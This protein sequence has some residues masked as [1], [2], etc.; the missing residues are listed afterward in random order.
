MVLALGIVLIIGL[1]MVII[2]ALIFLVRLFIALFEV[3]P[4]L[5][6]MVLGFIIV[7]VGC[8]FIPV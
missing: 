7:L 1:A 4:L 3:T 8:C 6:I 2:P 5:A